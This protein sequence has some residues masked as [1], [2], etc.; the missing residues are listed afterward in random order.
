METQ[1]AVETSPRPSIPGTLVAPEGADSLVVLSHGIFVT[2][3]ENGRFD[4]LSELLRENGYAS[5]RFDLAGHGESEV[6]PI[7]TTVARMAQELTDVC[8]WAAARFGTVHLVASSFSGALAALSYSDLEP[9]IRRGQLVLLNPVL[10]F[11]D[12]FIQP[13]KDEMAEIF[14]AS[15]Q[16]QAKRTG[17]F[18]PQPHFKMS[19]TMLFE[20]EHMDVPDAYRAIDRSHLVIHGDAD[21]LISFDTTSRLANEN[22]HAEFVRIPGAVHAFTQSGHE[23]DV[24]KHVISYLNAGRRNG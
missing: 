4:R 23:Y 1:I 13:A 11:V 8:H 7:D 16:Q 12:S 6:A 18:S 21:E 24:W 19:R 3:S 5:L 10:D 22:M 14:S 9:A 15:A 20:L 2:R 17:W